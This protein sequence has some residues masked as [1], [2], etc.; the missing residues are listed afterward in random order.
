M[1]ENNKLI[2][3]SNNSLVKKATISLAITNK[4]VAENN[5]QMVVEIFRKNPKLFLDLI[6][7]NYPL[8]L[9]FLLEFK[10]I[11]NWQLLSTNENLPWSAEFIENFKDKW[12]WKKLSR[13]KS[14][15][16]SI[17]FIE[18]YKDKWDWK[19]LYE[20]EKLPWTLELIDKFKDKLQVFN[21]SY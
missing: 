14:L 8:D 16:W 7:E 18:Y 12:D 13:N 6:S 3:I 19:S 15:P 10:D 2:P 20:N 11:L 5:K 1:E 21:K 17:E 4:L 9:N